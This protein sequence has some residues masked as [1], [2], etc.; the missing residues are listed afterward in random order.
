MFQRAR[1]IGSGPVLFK[2]VAQAPKLQS[3]F[4]TAVFSAGAADREQP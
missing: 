4:L 2:D 3:Y 1:S